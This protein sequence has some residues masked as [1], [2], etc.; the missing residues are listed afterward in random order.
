MKRR[1]LSEEAQARF[2][3]ARFEAIRRIGA[4]ARAED[5]ELVLVCGDVFESNAVDRRTVARAL[6]ALAD[7][8]VPVYL[9]PGNHDPLDGGSVYRS[10]A[11]L[12]A[13]PPHVHVLADTTP[14][15]VRPGLEIVGMPW[16]SKRPGRDLVAE[17]CAALTR[18]D[19]VTRIAAAH[20]CVDALSPDRND[21]ARISLAAAERA[22]ADGRIHF[23]A[24]G[25]RHS[26][27]A[28]GTSGRVQ[29]A[30]APEPTDWNE[31]QP[32]FVG[33]VDVDPDRAV[34]RSQPVARWR[35]E[36]RRGVPVSSEA[37]LDALDRTLGELP[38]KGRCILRLD[39]EG[40]LDLRGMARLEQLLERARDVFACVDVWE[41]DNRLAV[42]PADQ[43]FASLG[44]SG[45]AARAVDDLRARAGDDD[46]AA[47]DAL[48]LLV[49][50]AEGAEAR[51]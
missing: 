9:L 5:C 41:P 46:E 10:R 25:D 19:G 1:F 18:G 22:L 23:L 7:V 38:D 43:D 20:G 48:A 31:E 49:R 51:T 40:T 3:E 4:I 27:T 14:R 34:V 45:F 35:F 15:Q 36:R 50:L 17:A 11:F 28:V 47:R 12:A 30:G 2:D 29:Y 13:A 37:D 26:W 42:L 24:L 33:V 32:G 8:T 39:F 21:P 16:A 6:E 44:L